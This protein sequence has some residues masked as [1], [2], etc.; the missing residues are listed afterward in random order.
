[1][2]EEMRNAIG[3]CADC[4]HCF[5][6]VLELEEGDTFLFR[7][8]L[9]GYDLEERTN[10]CSHFEERNQISLFLSEQFR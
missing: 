1:M 2:N 8:L 4:L 10:T 3:V 5:C 6:R 9:S 7:C